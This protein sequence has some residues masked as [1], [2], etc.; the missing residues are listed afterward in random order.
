MDSLLQDLRFAARQ[1]ARRPG[2][3][4]SIV[5]ALALGIG[6][7]TAMFTVVNGVL[8]QPLPY[9]DAE[10][11]LLLLAESSPGRPRGAVSVPNYLDWKEQSTGLEQMGVWRSIDFNLRLADEPTRIQGAY[12]TSGVL[13]ALGV[14]PIAG[15]S[16]SDDDDRPGAPPSVLVR[17]DFWRERMG[18]DPRAVGKPIVLD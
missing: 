13:L 4:A 5:I 7:N 3:S 9:T 14:A 11:R 15:R 1:L 18:A 8:L 12:V 17:E 2:F 16:L 10:D 6:A